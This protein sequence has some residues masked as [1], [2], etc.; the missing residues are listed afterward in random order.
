METFT[1]FPL[2]PRD[3]QL[4]IWE[5][6]EASGIR[7]HLIIGH[8]Q[9]AYAAIDPSHDNALIPN[10]AGEDDPL[11]V[12]LD[13]FCKHKF[14]KIKLATPAFSAPPGTGNVSIWAR[15]GDNWPATERPS[16]MYADLERDV[17]YVAKTRAETQLDPRGGCLELYPAVCWMPEAL[18]QVRHIAV[19]VG[20]DRMH[21]AF[22][23]LED[24]PNLRTV[25]VV[26]RRRQQEY[27]RPDADAFLRRLR[28]LPRDAFGFVELHPFC[29]A[30]GGADTA[31]RTTFNLFGMKIDKIRRAEWCNRYTV[32]DGVEKIPVVDTG[33][34]GEW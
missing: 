3:T 15:L 30:F 25:R 21:G 22:L 26:L 24:F 34:D 28:G 14:T 13:P 19:P 6:Y 9:I 4:M 18:S 2:L 29:D 31:W 17:F 11:E 23:H 7:H 16:Y 8:R 12:R 32:K 1:Y 5:L 27:T 33:F 20:G 10:D